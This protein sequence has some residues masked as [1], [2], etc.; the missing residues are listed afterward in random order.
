MKRILTIAFISFLYV[1]QAQQ[2]ETRKITALDGISAAT[3]LRVEYVHAN[4]NEVVIETDHAAHLPLIETN[5]KNGVLYVQ[6]KRNS[7]IKNGR[8]NRVI[9][10][11]SKI[12]TNFTASSS[13]SI[14]S[15]ESIQANKITVSVS[16]SAKIELKK[17]IA[18]DIALS[19]SSS[20]RLITAV[21]AKNLEIN[22]TSSSKQTIAGSA[23]NLRL[24]AS[25]STAV[26]MASFTVT[27]A[28]INASSSAAITLSVKDNLQGKVST[29]AKISLKNRP[30]NIQ[31][32]K[33]TSGQVL[34]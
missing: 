27:N 10:Y 1:A 13:G 28:Q 24:N 9:V 30:R 3:S 21:S 32:D 20:S 31:V 6:Y 33:S 16:S 29:S 23:T 19:T 17:L 4:R 15:S 7:Q 25:S 18:N 5:V 22:S 14:Y 2:R 11:S 26:D 8:N 12:P 34:L